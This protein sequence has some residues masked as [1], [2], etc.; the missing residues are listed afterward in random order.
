MFC[1][2]QNRAVRDQA[3]LLSAVL[4]WKGFVFCWTKSPLKKISQGLSI[5]LTEDPSEKV[6]SA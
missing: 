5:L 6:S 3:A 2:G 4:C 1:E